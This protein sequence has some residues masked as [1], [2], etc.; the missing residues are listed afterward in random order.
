M[1]I[2]W[3]VKLGGSLGSCGLLPLWLE[4][5]SNCNVLIVPGGGRFA[6]TVRESQARWGFND[7][8][9]HAMA[10]LAMAQYGRMLQGIC[11]GLLPASNRPDVEQILSAGRSA[12]WLPDAALLTEPALQAS[13][14]VT[15]DS[16]ALWWANVLGAGQLLL[17]KS[18]IP[19]PVSCAIPK[20]MDAGLIDRAFSRYKAKISPII[21]ITGPEDY[22]GLQTKLDQPERFFTRIV[23]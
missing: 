23:S 20:L 12:V 7:Q 9:A 14:D 11:P 1:P 10:I 22:R 15:S 2:R 5:L 4:Q 8:T 3:L 16:L 17:I 13:W 19:P 18:A 21:W 6:D